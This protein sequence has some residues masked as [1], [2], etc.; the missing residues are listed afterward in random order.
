M[1]SI[2]YSHSDKVYVKDCTACNTR[3]KVE[4]INITMAELL[5]F[6]HFS[7]NNR[8]IN[9]LSTLCRSCHND[10]RSGRTSKEH[11]NELLKL[12]DDKCAICATEITFAIKNKANVDHCHIT[13]ITRGV[14]CIKC[15]NGMHYVDDDEWLVKAIAYRDSFR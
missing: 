15:N 13:Q 4:A 14:L 10:S 7:S 5:M 1:P 6:E 11:R 12:Q 3:F 2:V 8:T 9:N